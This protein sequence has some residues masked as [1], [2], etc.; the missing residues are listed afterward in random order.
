MCLEKNSTLHSQ[1][2]MWERLSFTATD[3]ANHYGKELK[4]LTARTGPWR[5]VRF[6]KRADTIINLLMDI[7]PSPTDVLDVFKVWLNQY[8]LPFVPNK[9]ACF[10]QFHAKYSKFILKTQ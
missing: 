7:D 2:L 1:T 3:F 9:L 6:H 5:H 10:D 8:E 4:C